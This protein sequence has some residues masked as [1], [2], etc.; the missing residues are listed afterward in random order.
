VIV[1]RIVIQV[2]LLCES[3]TGPVQK[4]ITIEKG[5]A[6]DFDGVNRDSQ[7]QSKELY[8]WGQGEDVDI[9]DGKHSSSLTCLILVINCHPMSLSSIRSLGIPKLC[10]G[11][12]CQQSRGEAEHSSYASEGSARKRNDALSSP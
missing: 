9:K 5:V 4:I 2:K 8:L 6:L 10:I 12:T 11:V 3:S 1:L 7:A